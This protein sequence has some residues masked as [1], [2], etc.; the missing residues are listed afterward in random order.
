MFEYF[1]TLNM[2]T[3]S[4]IFKIF[5]LGACLTAVGMTAAARSM[6]SEAESFLSSVPADLQS[7]QELAVRKAMEG[8]TAP[9]DSVRNSRNAA[10]ELP[11]GVKAVD[12]DGLYRL[13]TPAAGSDRPLPVLV[14]LH[15]GGWCFG[16][17]NSCSRFCAEFV[18]ES[19]MAV[20][21]VEYPLA[22]EHPYPSALN[23]CVDAVAYVSDNARE[24]GLDAGAISVGGDSSGG[25]L[26][27]ATAL[28]LVYSEAI[29]AGRDADAVLPRLKS[30]VLFYPVVKAWN[31][32]S[33]SWKQYGK[34]YGLDSGIM[35][36]FNAAYIGDNDPCMPLISPYCAAEEHL[37]QLPPA[38]IINASDDILCDQGREMQELLAKAGADVRREVFPGASHLFITVAGQPTAFR[39]AVEA[40]A[41]FID[42]VMR[43]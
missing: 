3:M 14:Y 1:C 40:A 30:L 11:D 10:A 15:G 6:E 39:R 7:R 26:A 22:P 17:I 43:R 28:R 12:I 31:D 34:G 4:H 18:R 32:G 13:Y 36:A 35:E 20:L 23:A 41:S 2:I 24:L 9:L 29:V 19:G 16:S 8:D 21:A 37:A 25:N 27:L 38:L 42:S 5:G 33:D